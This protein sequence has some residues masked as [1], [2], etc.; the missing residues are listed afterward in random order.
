MSV[1][2]SSGHAG[3]RQAASVPFDG[4]PPAHE[5]EHPRALRGARETA[6][7]EIPGKI[8]VAPRAIATLAGRAVADCYGV[9]G[10]AARHLRFGAVEVLAP[11]QYGRGVEVRFSDDTITIDVYVVLEHGLR[12]TEIAHNIMA[13]VKYVVERALGLRVVR[14]NVNVQALRIDGGGAAG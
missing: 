14:I 1:E 10:I 5:H 3:T 6:R 2:R 7:R 8:E 13:T 12:I 11:E 9:V 4:R